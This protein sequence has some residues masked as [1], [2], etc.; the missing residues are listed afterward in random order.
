M[1]G[2][3]EIVLASEPR[4]GGLSPRVRGNLNGAYTQ[5][6]GYGSIPA[7]AGEPSVVRGER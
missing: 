4:F 7:C 3:T 6:A 2:G 1:C 5:V